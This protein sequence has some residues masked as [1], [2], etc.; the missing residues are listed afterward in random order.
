MFLED[1]SSLAVTFNAGEGVTVPQGTVHY[2][3]NAACTQ[4]EIVVVFDHPDPA[5]VYVGQAVTQFPLAYLD[6]AFENSPSNITSNQF[7]ISPCNCD[8]ASG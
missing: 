7:I 3:R 4:S 8:S 2:A 6:S 5:T 1:T